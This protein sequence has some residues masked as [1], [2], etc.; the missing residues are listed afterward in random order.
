[1]FQLAEEQV[2]Q[3]AEEQVFQLAE[4]QVFQL[5]EEQVFRLVACLQFPKAA[6]LLLTLVGEWRLQSLRPWSHRHQALAASPKSWNFG[7]MYW[8]VQLENLLSSNQSLACWY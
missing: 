5:A 1:V 6:Y 2:F 8:V 4:E 3:L 7:E